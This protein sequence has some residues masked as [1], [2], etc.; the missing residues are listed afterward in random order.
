MRGVA[1]RCG[2]IDV[3]LAVQRDGLDGI[4]CGSN[5]SFGHRPTTRIQGNP[6][7]GGDRNRLVNGT[8]EFVQRLD[9][10]LGHDGGGV[11]ILDIT[12]N[13]KKGG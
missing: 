2:E 3:R 6:G 7:L 5:Q 13:K 9:C 4:G 10:L 12:Q 1:R 8:K 11:S